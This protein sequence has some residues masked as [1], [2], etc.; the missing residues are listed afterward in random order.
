MAKPR[1]AAPPAAKPKFCTSKIREIAEVK[2]CNFKLKS[3]WSGMGDECPNKENHL[4]PMLSG[5]CHSGWH[6][7]TKAVTASGKPAPTCKHY[8]NCPCDCHARLN[9]MFQLSGQERILVDQSQ[10]KADNPYVLPSL[11]DVV[12][13][14]PFRVPGI[15]A[16]VVM[17]SPAPE[18]VPAAI[19]RTFTVTPT[20]RAGRGELETWVREITDIWAVDQEGLCTP[21]YVSEYIARR[22]GINAPSVGAVDAVFNRWQTLGFAKIERKPTRFEGYTE[23]GIRLGLDTMKARAKRATTR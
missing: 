11:E 14:A 16:A 18:I 21:K 5:F 2:V 20:G 23:D 12:T 6:E 4:N 1:V 8:I 10:W 13:A 7:G 3:H 22:K 9:R 19:Q 15:V 17:E